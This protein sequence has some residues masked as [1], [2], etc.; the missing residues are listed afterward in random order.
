MSRLRTPDDPG[1]LRGWPPPDPGLRTIYMK[2]SEL[3]PEPVEGW[4]LIDR[5]A[6]DGKIAEN[7]TGLCVFATRADC[8]RLIKLW[9]QTAEEHEDEA[10]TPRRLRE[11]DPIRERMG[12]RPVR[13]SV[14]GGVEFLDDGV[15]PKVRPPIC[16]ER[17][18][19]WLKEPMEDVHGLFEQWV[20]GWAWHDQDQY[21]GEYDAAFRAWE[22]AATFFG[23]RGSDE[24]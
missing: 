24:G 9:E 1:T 7:G 11:R 8:E 20:K 2:I 5:D 14:E 4:A 21:P 15:E 23:K 18:P 22:D 6:G 3:V 19:H 17:R 12:I 10:C 13:I 16:P